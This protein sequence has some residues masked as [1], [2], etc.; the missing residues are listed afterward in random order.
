MNKTI[1]TTTGI[2]IITLLAV[3]V[4][5]SILFLN[6]EVKYGKIIEEEVVGRR[7]NIEEEMPYVLAGK[8][9]DLG[10]MVAMDDCNDEYGGDISFSTTKDT[11][12]INEDGE[13]LLINNMQIGDTVSVWITGPIRESLPAQATAKKIVL[14]N[15]NRPSGEIDCYEISENAVT[16]S[17]TIKNGKKT[18]LVRDNKTIATWTDELKEGL[19]FD[20]RLYRDTL[21]N[22]YL[23]NDG[24]EL[25]LDII[26]KISCKTKFQDKKKTEEDC[27]KDIESAE[28]I[29]SEIMSA[30]YT[31]E[32]MEIYMKCGDVL[33][34]E[35][36]LASGAKFLRDRDWE[37]ISKSEWD[38]EEDK[39][40]VV[41]DVSN[42]ES[43]SPNFIDCPMIIDDS[44]SSNVIIQHI[45]GDTYKWEIYDLGNENYCVILERPEK[46]RLSGEEA[47]SLIKKSRGQ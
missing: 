1:S 19:V 23:I 37:E 22:Y 46:K 47:E 27:V 15:E 30:K 25:F 16:I 41:M 14:R 34:Y 24:Q 7:D 39:K 10:L 20:E 4:G 12:I 2:L 36:P 13:E 11:V 45:E 6:E 44:V 43:Y 42:I 40:K 26:D 35:S 38:L 3:A 32:P 5:T 17:Y 18:S 28:E 9:C 21:H 31:E 29:M 8:I 33:F